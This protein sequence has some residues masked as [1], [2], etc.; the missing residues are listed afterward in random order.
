MNNVFKKTLSLILSIVVCIGA[1][2]APVNQA[3][4]ET[5]TTTTW[6]GDNVKLDIV[7]GED[8]YTYMLFGDKP[9]Y[10]YYET[11]NHTV[12]KEVTKGGAVHVLGLI[13]TKK[14]KGEWTPNGLYEFGKSN[15]DLVY[16]CDAA[17][18]SEAGNYYKRLNLEDSEYFTVDEAEKLRA[19]LSN[20]YP[21]VSV[22]EAKA[23]L[24]AAGFAQADELDR[25][26]LITATQ[27]AVWSIANKGNGD[28]YDYAKTASTPQKHTWG[29]NLHDFSA[30]IVNFTDSASKKYMTPAGVGDRI[31]AL[32]DF[33]LAMEGVHAENDQIV[34]S[35]IDIK[36]SKIAGSRDTYKVTLDVALNHG[37]DDNDSVT[38][39]VYV[40]G[41]LTDVTVEVNEASEYT[42]SLEAKANDTIKVEVTGTQ[43][44]EKGVYFYAPKPQDIDG[45]GI[46]TS[47]EVSQNLI[48][49][50]AGETPVHAE[51]TF[52][53]D[54]IDV[55][56]KLNKVDTKGNPLTG[57][58]F[59][60]Y[61]E[62]GNLI[63]SNMVDEN[64]VL[65]F[66][67]L[68]PGKY[69]ISETIVPEGYV[70]LGGDI[71][72]VISDDG[73]IT[74]LDMPEGVSFNNDE[75]VFTVINKV[76]PK[77]FDITGTKLLDG[78]VAKDFEFKLSTIENGEVTSTQ[79]ALS[80]LD[81]L[82]NFKV[83]FAKEG[84]YTFTVEEEKGTD[85]TIV[86]DECVY[87]LTI[88]VTEVD[89]E[90]VVDASILKDGAEADGD[91]VFENTTVP[92]NPANVVIEGNK[93]LDGEPAEDEFTFELWYNGKLIETVVNGTD[94]KF[95]FSDLIFDAEGTYEYVV[96]EYI[97]PEND[98]ID[99]DESVYT[100]V[101][102]VTIEDGVNYAAD[103]TI[104]KTV[105][106][107]DESVNEIVF[108]N[109]YKDEDI[110][111]PPPP[112]DPGEEPELGS[113]AETVWTLTLILA[114]L[115]IVVTTMK[116]RKVQE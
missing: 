24:K 27:A 111:N 49:I 74:V 6:Y 64:G 45:N 47:R 4:A 52:T 30:E 107:E 37:A 90:F 33:Y 26:E 81:G 71:V 7:T 79:T 44:L 40:N 63:D 35:K 32:R 55:D 14:Y 78:D 73:E 9:N 20:S 97:D 96:K 62:D 99:F 65:V 87:T 48:G 95:T 57:A 93:N 51:R 54:V 21:F 28:S 72:F 29:G 42:V 85:E 13:D 23:A 109:E 16:C 102:N 88:T 75:F 46:A 108:N 77:D 22:E 83:Q 91:I 80:G 67:G 110:P 103:V 112:K 50:A 82:F 94:G 11:S 10:Y 3:F 106:G 56:I 98:Y 70:G 19:I 31:N 105:D 68:V 2:F 101:I 66:E 86:Y 61:D 8:A 43:N 39:N 92:K 53:I 15:Y 76:S 12:L 1:I 59:A 104:T 60:V 69:Q 17:T 34:I 25:S 58:N 38:L 100:I 41:V 36:N 116:K 5:G 89:G 115:G 84:T 18:G 113:T 114:M